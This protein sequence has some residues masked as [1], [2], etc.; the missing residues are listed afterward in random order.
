MKETELKTELPPAPVATGKI[1]SAL[2]KAQAAFTTI[3]K[4]GSMSYQA[5]KLFHYATLDDILAGVKPALNANGLF[6]FQDVR[7]ITQGAESRVGVKTIVVHESGER[8]ESAELYMPV[9]AG[10]G[11]R[12]QAFG[13]AR[14]YACRYSLASF[15]GI[16]AE[17][18][19]DGNVPGMQP[20]SPAPRAPARRA[21]KPQTFEPEDIPY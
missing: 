1:Y 11:N 15:L 20:E 5:G 9:E 3:K 12:A 16:S 13:S 7:C 21:V 17:D 19:T 10:R 2:C 6:L 14:T 4:S 8:L 18:D